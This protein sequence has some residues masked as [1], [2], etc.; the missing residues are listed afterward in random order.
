MLDASINLWRTAW[1]G[2]ALCGFRIAFGDRL[3]GTVMFRMDYDPGFMSRHPR[4]I[5]GL[6]M[7]RF[8]TTSDTKESYR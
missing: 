6:W 1:E 5:A 8:E 4:Q 2:M 3:V 7:S